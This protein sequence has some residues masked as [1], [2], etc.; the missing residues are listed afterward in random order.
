MHE[1][2]SPSVTPED[3]EALRANPML[4]VADED[5]RRNGTVD[6]QNFSVP[7]PSGAPEISLLVLRPAGLAAGAPV[8]YHIHGGMIIGDRRTGVDGV[9][10]SSLKAG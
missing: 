6:L 2:L 7:G 1:Q 10:D 9:L 5:L 4:A 8:F 3:I